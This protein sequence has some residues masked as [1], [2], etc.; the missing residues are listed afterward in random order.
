[1]IT[2]DSIRAAVRDAF[3]TIV[4]DL[5]DLVAIPSVSAASHDQAEVLRSAEHVAG[6][7]RNAGLEA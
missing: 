7:L 2:V 1:M 4:S 3:P 5:T 6:L